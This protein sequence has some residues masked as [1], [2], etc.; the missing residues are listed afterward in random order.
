MITSKSHRL[1]EIENIRRLNEKI[2]HM[3]CYGYND[4]ANI[5]SSPYG[6]AFS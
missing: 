5:A 6:I 4:L 2:V 3:K 1:L